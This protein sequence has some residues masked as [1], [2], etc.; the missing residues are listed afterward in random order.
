MK[1]GEFIVST[2]DLKGIITSVNEPFTN[3]C[4][5][6]KSELIGKNHN[7]VRHPDM[8]PIAFQG[9][10]D[11]L[12]VKNTW[13]GIVKNRCKNG[14]FYWVN[15]NV[16]PLTEN[17]EIT[18]YMSVRTIPSRQDVEAAE[19]L[20]QQIN[21]GTINLNPSIATKVKNSLK[22]QSIGKFIFL[23][24]T[25]ILLSIWSMA[26]LRFTE[27]SL[28]YSIITAGLTSVFLI[29][30]TTFFYKFLSKQFNQLIKTLSELMEGNFKNWLTFDIGG[31]VGKILHLLKSVQIL[32]GHNHNKSNEV[33]VVQRYANALE[34]VYSSVLLLDTNNEIIFFNK[35]FAKLIDQADKRF[36]EAVPGLDTKNLLGKR[37]NL[38]FDIPDFKTT[39]NKRINTVIKIDTSV[40]GCPVRL[41]V[42]P[43]VNDKGDNLGSIL[44][45]DQFQDLI[46]E[47]SVRQVVE[48]AKS[49][50]LTQRVN[51]E[52]MQ[53]CVL[54]LSQGVNELL[55]V[56]GTVINDVSQVMSAMSQG[57]LSYK[58]EGKYKGAFK[59]LKEYVNGSISQITTV[60]DDITDSANLVR[61]GSQ[62]IALGNMDLSK[63]TNQQSSSLEDTASS[64]E[65]ITSIVKQNADNA[66]QANDLASGVRAEA[67][68]SGDVV[69]KAIEAMSEISGSSEK[70]ATIIGT[71]DEIA[72]QTNLL[73]L[74]AAVE[75]A[76][77]GEQGRGFAV[78]ATEVRNLAGRSAE[79][80]GEI[81]LL[82][83]ASVEKVASG[84]KLVNESGETLTQI[85]ESVSKVNNIIAEIADSS[86]EQSLGIDQANQAIAKMDIMTQQNAVLVKEAANAS[87]GMDVQAGRLG[88]LVGFFSTHKKASEN[89]IS[90]QSARGKKTAQLQ[91]HS[92]DIEH[93]PSGVDKAAGWE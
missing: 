37:V 71:I 69:N 70:M 35:S 38:F 89:N 72:F 27:S 10:W 55:T 67:E 73:A 11:T 48:S 47:D 19:K 43:I 34:N 59:E 79:A 56:C 22:Q 8:P 15:A 1:E 13:S 66:L 24:S 42:S 75:A 83:E 78:V 36:L 25:V 88:E 7:I 32:I 68:V 63:R 21:Q 76:R 74:N 57:D 18:G 92:K 31:E 65:E 30:S 85:I 90:N 9:L 49:G 14:D 62:E 77:A 4:G 82:I 91:L 39:F 33:A 26:L 44:E 58:I 52:N 51:V 46:T 20:Y 40:N 80:A 50:D 60:I 53:G 64:M 6:D 28:I 2:T 16:T 87:T 45:W 61:T 41:R 86:R 81:K 23:Y 54:S 17:G 93:I 5:Y 12:K 84:S 3:I 29:T